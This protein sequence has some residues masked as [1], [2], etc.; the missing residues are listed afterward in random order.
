[1]NKSQLIGGIVCLVLAAG[2][3]A[4]AIGLSPEKVWFAVMVG[5]LNISLVAVALLIIG[6]LL[7]V[8]LKKQ[9]S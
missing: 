8:T 7:L 5:G 2:F 1:M 4:T 9:E 3:Q 6:V